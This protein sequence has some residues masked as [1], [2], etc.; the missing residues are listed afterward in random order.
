M[1][2]QAAISRSRPECGVLIQTSASSRH[3]PAT[4]ATTGQVQGLVHL[5]YQPR[6][7]DGDRT[8]HCACSQS[9]VDRALH[10]PVICRVARLSATWQ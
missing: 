8:G 1:H 5:L 9:G 4:L 2:P 6:L 3:V 7:D 10:M